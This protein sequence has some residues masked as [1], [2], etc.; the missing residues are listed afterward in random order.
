MPRVLWKYNPSQSIDLSSA[1]AKLIILF[2]VIIYL[3]YPLE[4]FKLSSIE[5]ALQYRLKLINLNAN[6][7][8]KG[9]A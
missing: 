1:G 8:D 6:D 9:N 5:A 4:G 7:Q 2:A 3:N